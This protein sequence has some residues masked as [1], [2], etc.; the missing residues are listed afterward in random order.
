MNRFSAIAL[1]LVLSVAG[2]GIAFA[3]T[4]VVSQ[5]GKSFQPDAVAV[6]KG[7][8]VRFVNDDTVSHNVHSRHDQADFNVGLQK[9]GDSSDVTFTKVGE[10]E[11]RCAIHPNMKMKV[12]VTE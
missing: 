3:D 8:Q 1:A 10:F 5:K 4:P 9:P 2:A 7:G 11:I 12:K 6:A